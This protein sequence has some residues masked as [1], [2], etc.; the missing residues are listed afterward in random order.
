MSFEVG[1]YLTTSRAGHP[2]HGQTGQIISINTA[3]QRAT[4]DWDGDGV[5]EVNAGVRLNNA[6]VT[7]KL[8]SEFTLQNK[9]ENVEANANG[10]LL[11]AIGIGVILIGWLYVRRLVS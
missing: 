2:Y 4:V 11:I 1:D 5:A 6:R 9:F 7:S 10:A 8:G 3:N